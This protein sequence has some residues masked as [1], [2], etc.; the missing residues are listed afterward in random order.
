MVYWYHYNMEGR[1]YC[2]FFCAI[3]AIPEC[4]SLV[5]IFWNGDIVKLKEF[6]CLT[7]LYPI[8]FT[9]PSYTQTKS[10]KSQNA[11]NWSLATTFHLKGSELLCRT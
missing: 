2:K 11:L 7:D 4:Q 10:E 6:V 3:K 9:I 1:T 8:A 5:W